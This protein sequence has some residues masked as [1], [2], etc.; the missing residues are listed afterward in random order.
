MTT[1]RSRMNVPNLD[2]QFATKKCTKKLHK[3]L[4]TVFQLQCDSANISREG[5]VNSFCTDKGT[6]IPGKIKKTVQR[7]LFNDRV[8]Q[9]RRACNSSNC[10]YICNVN[11]ITN[12]QNKNNI[13]KIIQKRI[14][15]KVKQ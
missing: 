15:N 9:P 3:W 6:N 5:R 10:L 13:V 8:N 4:V 2:C 11:C 1:L 7:Q 12:K 14:Q